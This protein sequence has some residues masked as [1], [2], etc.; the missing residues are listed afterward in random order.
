MRTIH[1]PV[2]VPLRLLKRLVALGL[3][4]VGFGSLLLLTDPKK[5]QAVFSEPQGPFVLGVVLIA[6]GV[7]ISVVGAAGLILRASWQL[8]SIEVESSGS[9]VTGA[10]VT[11]K[12][13]DLL[14]IR[15]GLKALKASTVRE[16]RCALVVEEKASSGSTRAQRIYESVAED[17]TVKGQALQAGKKLSCTFEQR[18]PVDVE[19][20]SDRRFWAIEVEVRADGAPDF[21][22]RQ[23]LTV[24]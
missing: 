16:A 6:L 24:A 1:F 20:S 12:R 7:S 14:T 3:V 18:L 15:L 23:P 5:M 2:G 19:P 9:K 8:S 21:L 10:T 22:H 4:L 17:A 13:G 11:T